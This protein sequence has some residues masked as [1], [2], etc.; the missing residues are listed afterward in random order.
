V[1]VCVCMHMY[2]RRAREGDFCP[3]LFM[4]DMYVCMYVRMYVRMHA[5][6][7]ACMYACMHVCMYVCIHELWI[8][9][10]VYVCDFHLMILRNFVFGCRN[11]S[12][13]RTV[14]MYTCI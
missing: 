13:A 7:Y 4:R 14:S 9:C 3:C 5:C 8:A 12:T 10:M 6:M 2:T 1:Y 11:N